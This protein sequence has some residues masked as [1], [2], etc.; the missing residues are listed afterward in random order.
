MPG[1]SD[2][3]RYMQ[4]RMHCIEQHA[5]IQQAYIEQGTMLL[6]LRHDW[7]LV[8]HMAGYTCPR[9]WELLPLRFNMAAGAIFFCD[10]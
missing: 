5:I 9:T 6:G 10:A 4:Q 8:Q 3:H 1:S 7:Q 2:P